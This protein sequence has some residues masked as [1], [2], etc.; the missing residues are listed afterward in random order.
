MFREV[1][2]KKQML[3]PEETI[4]ILKRGTSGVLAVWGDDGY[5][6]A[7]PLSY[8]YDNGKIIFHSGKKGHKIDGILRNPKASF[9]VI[10]R[11]QVAPAEYTTH[12]RSVIVFGKLRILENDQEK[13]ESIEKLALKYAPDDTAENRRKTIDQEWKALCVLEMQIE[14]VTGKKAA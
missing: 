9:C 3:S 5:P 7:V 4:A 1:R 8:V 14:Y 6:Y 11:D 10:D 2:L 13:R 12:Y